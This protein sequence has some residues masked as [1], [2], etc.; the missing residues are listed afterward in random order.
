MGGENRKWPNPLNQSDNFTQIHTHP[1]EHD[2]CNSLVNGR[3]CKA[4]CLSIIQSSAAS[5]LSDARVI[6]TAA[7]TPDTS[8][9]KGEVSLLKHIVPNLL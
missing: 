6:I 5:S 8:A 9:V 4:D 7:Q 3:G 1:V 2:G